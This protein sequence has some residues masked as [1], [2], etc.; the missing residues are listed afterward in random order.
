M[1]SKA[2][3]PSLRV[4]QQRKSLDA[5]RNLFALAAAGLF[6]LP[7]L[8]TEA[9]T[10]NVVGSCTLVNS[11]LSA[12]TNSA[13]GGC[14]AGAAGLDTIVLPAN[15]TQTLTAVYDFTALYGPSGLPE[16]NSEIV[17]EGNGSTILRDPSSAAFRIFV[18]VEG[19]NLSLRQSTVSGGSVSGSDGGG[20]AVYGG[21]LLELNESTVSGNSTGNDGGGIYN[22]SS[23]LF[24]TDSTVSGNSAF[25]GG[26][27]GTRGSSSITTV[28]GSTVSGNRGNYG[29]GVNAFG[30]VTIGSSTIS[31]NSASRDGGGLIAIGRVSIANTTITANTA[32]DAH[33]GGVAADLD[34]DLDITASIIAGNSSTDIDDYGGYGG[35]FITGGN[36]LIG[37]G[38]FASN[39]DDATDTINVANPMLGP[40][41]DN[42]GPTFTHALLTG[43]PAIDSFESAVPG[44]VANLGLVEF[45]PAGKDQRGVARPQDGD[46]DGDAVCDIGAFELE[47]AM[48]DDADNDG[49]PD[50]MDNCPMTPNTDQLDTDE[51]GIGDACDDSPLGRCEGRAVTIRG[52][53]NNDT[54]NGTNGA[55]VMDGLGG[56]DTINGRGGND[57]ICGGPGDD[58][59]KGGNGNDRILGNQGVDNLQGEAGNDELLG[60]DGRDSL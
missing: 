40:L 31:G 15:S 47:G 37:D 59:I 17:I 51:D 25:Y 9:A 8:S 16:I 54:L 60:G 24:V 49:I 6:I 45:C 35:T 56:K 38:N 12:N 1:K 21:G 4:Q 36:N 5:R 48:G 55:D 50:A 43:S 42:D 22:L 34:D 11:I 29:G 32:P 13:V 39:F 2:I 58:T 52:T 19:G 57:W 41:A 26:G 23:T 18:V 46:G 10:I 27:I 14:T 44:R 3:G 7:S 28:T 53:L 30:S 20:L 33:G